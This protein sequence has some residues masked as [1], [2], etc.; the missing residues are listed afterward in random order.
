[1]RKSSKPKEP[2]AAK[3][4]PGDSFSRWC[5][6]WSRFPDRASLARAKSADLLN[7]MNFWIALPLFWTPPSSGAARAAWSVYGARAAD[8]LALAAAARALDGLKIEAAHKVFREHI[9]LAKYYKKA[10]EDEANKNKGGYTLFHYSDMLLEVFPAGRGPSEQER[11]AFREGLK[12]L[13]RLSYKLETEAAVPAARAKRAENRRRRPPLA[14][15]V[16]PLTAKQTEALQI[17]GE[18]K[19][20]Y[21]DAAKRMGLNRKT[22]K[23]HYEVACRKMGYSV[24]KTKT[25]SIPLDRR[26]QENVAGPDDGPAALESRKPVVSRDRRG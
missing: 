14:S 15:K 4:P 26:G 22:V 18:C 20:S 19:G 10:A 3:A 6:W 2:P 11:A 8:A 12:E 13:K 23:Q 16:R 9:D 7:M 17:V 21:A 5:K 24:S 25:L 1:M